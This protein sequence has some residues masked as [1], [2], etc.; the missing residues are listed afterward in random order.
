MSAH[1]AE[2]AVISTKKNDNDNIQLDLSSSAY[3]CQAVTKQIWIVP[4]Q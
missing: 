1:L 2:K 3:S 4:E